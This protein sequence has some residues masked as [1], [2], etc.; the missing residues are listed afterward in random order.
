MEQFGSR[1]G[2]PVEECLK[3]V[4]S[5]Q[6]YV[7]VFIP[8]LIYSLNEDYP[9]PP[10]HFETGLGAEKL[11]VL[12]EQLKKRHTTSFFTT[13]EDLQARITQD[14]PAQLGHMGVEVADTLA[15]A[16]EISDREVLKKFE[17]LPKLF[18]DRSR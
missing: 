7:G 2:S 10:K 3:V 17:I 9:I 16:E 4:Q 13:P 11:Q 18:S 5:C 12:K 6:L 15:K 1:P 8:S 14:V